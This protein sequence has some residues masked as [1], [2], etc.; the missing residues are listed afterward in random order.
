MI[1]T[2]DS[3]RRLR[4]PVEVMPTKPGDDFLV[5]FDPDEDM[6]VCH[7]ITP[8]AD[9]LAVD[10]IGPHSLGHAEDDDGAWSDRYL[11]SYGE[12]IGGGTSEIQR[13]IIAERVLGLPR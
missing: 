5:D 1:V 7:R 4:V 2:L 11:L 10:I 9:W 3:K 6:L 12:S 13:N 8:G